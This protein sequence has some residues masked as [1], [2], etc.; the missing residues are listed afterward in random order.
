MKHRQGMHK[1][2]KAMQG[3]R[4]CVRSWAVLASIGVAA[5]LSAPLMHFCRAGLFARECVVCTAPTKHLQQCP[6]ACPAVLLLPSWPRIAQRQGPS[7][8][9]W[10]HTN[11][12][13]PVHQAARC[14]DHVHATVSLVPAP[15]AIQNL[16]VVGE[17]RAAGRYWERHGM[18]RLGHNLSARPAS[19]ALLIHMGQVASCMPEG[20]RWHMPAGKLVMQSATAESEQCRSNRA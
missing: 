7:N 16:Q 20:W 5:K 4:A 2:I 13:A 14:Q 8:P 17:H 1:H 9:R 19:A 18:V 3:S 6:L 10:G 12:S 15:P 11:C